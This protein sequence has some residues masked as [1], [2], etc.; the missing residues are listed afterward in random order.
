M[1]QPAR[2]RQ[3]VVVWILGINATFDGPTFHLEALLSVA[4]LAAASDPDL[5]LDD[6]N[7]G[8][9]LSHRMLHLETGVHFK[10]VEVLVLIH[11]ELDR[12]GIQIVNCA[13]RFA[14]YLPHF[15]AQGLVD[16]R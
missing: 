13:S 6:V 5:L 15:G 3:E 16:E 14:G 9:H 1:S 7:A 4:Q 11:Q 12:S 2:R 10:E 8:N